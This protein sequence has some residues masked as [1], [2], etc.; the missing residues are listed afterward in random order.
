[1]IKAHTVPVVLPP[2]EWALTPSLPLET[3]LRLTPAFIMKGDG[4]K[5]KEG[6]FTV[7]M[8]DVAFLS[9]QISSIT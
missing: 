5:V 2:W 1:M 4:L 6:A 7:L 3:E 9:N 8:G